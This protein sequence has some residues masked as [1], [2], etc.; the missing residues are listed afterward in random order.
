M[1]LSTV[2]DVLRPTTQDVVGSHSHWRIQTKSRVASAP[3]DSFKLAYAREEIPPVRPP[4]RMFRVE[5][6]H[7]MQFRS[8]IRPLKPYTEEDRPVKPTKTLKKLTPPKAEKPRGRRHFD[9][10]ELVHA[11]EYNLDMLIPKRGRVF[12]EEG[13]WMPRKP[14]TEMPPESMM[15]RKKRVEDPRNG[16]PMRVPGEK[17]YKNPEYVPGY[18]LGE[19]FPRSEWGKITH[20]SQRQNLIMSMAPPPDPNPKPWYNVKRKV[21]LKRE[22]IQEVSDLDNWKPT[23]I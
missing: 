1:V 10:D 21:Q 22:E 19:V 11:E 5:P 16:I 18:Y 14:A 8:S 23:V 6:S 13:H 7:E 20:K 2:H 12:D 4:K 3:R 15:T 9:E 17:G